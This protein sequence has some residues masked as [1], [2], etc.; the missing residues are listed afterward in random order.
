MKKL[1]STLALA[2]LVS[3]PSVFSKESWKE[4]SAARQE[5]A[6]SNISDRVFVGLDN[7]LSGGAGFSF[8]KALGNDAVFQMIALPFGIWK[9]E[10][11]DA[12]TT[13]QLGGRFLKTV[14]KVNGVN[15]Q[16]GLGLNFADYGATSE[17]FIEAPIRFEYFVGPRVSFH[18]VSGL[19]LDL[20]ILQDAEGWNATLGGAGAGIS[21]YL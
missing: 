16:A 21:M 17:L 11:S 15:V 8:G 7:P 2:A 18:L 9:A 1:L 6:S 14:K 19:N 20:N 5:A 4:K 3:A 13:F 10:G 12:Q